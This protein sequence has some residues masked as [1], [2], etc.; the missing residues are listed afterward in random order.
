MT[1]ICHYSDNFDLAC[2]VPGNG[3]ALPNRILG[4]EERLHSSPIQDANVRS[5]ETILIPEIPAHQ[6]RNAHLIYRPESPDRFI[7][8]Q[9]PDCFFQAAGDRFRA[10][11]S[12]YNQVV[13]E[14]WALI[15]RYVRFAERRRRQTRVTHIPGHPD[16]DRLL[17]VLF[18]SFLKVEG[19]SLPNRILIAEYVLSKLLID[20]DDPRRGSPIV[21]TQ[22]AAY[23]QGYSHYGP[24]AW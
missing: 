22:E 16:D 10:G 23:A 19:Q 4:A 2:V 17:I 8:I 18:L 12:S 5:A 15:H 11:C 7:A 14:Q 24:I 9:G 20:H 13:I 21:W 3:K 6:H 1:D